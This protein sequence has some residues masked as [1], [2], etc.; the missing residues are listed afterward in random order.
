MIRVALALALLLVV[1][2]SPLPAQD[3]QG[4]TTI[5]LVRHAEKDTM[6]SDP[7]LTQRGRER[8][9]MLSRIVALT[10]VRSTHSTQYRRTVETVAPTDSALGLR[11]EVI[12][13]DPDSLPAHVA[14]LVEHLLSAHAGETTLVSSHSNVIPLILR[15]LGLDAPPIGDTDYDNLFVVTAQKKAQPSMLRLQMGMP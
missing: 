5:I 2:P 3:R 7:P 4:A 13:A 12:E 8:A 14:R 9:Q 11:N 10:G 15:A 1:V 6:K